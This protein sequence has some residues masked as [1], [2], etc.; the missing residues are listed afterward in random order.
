MQDEIAK[1]LSDIQ[2]ST[3]SI[4]DYLGKRDIVVCENNKLLRASYS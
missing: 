1:Y 3:N 2:V 4:F